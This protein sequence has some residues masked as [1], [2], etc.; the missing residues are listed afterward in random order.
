VWNDI[1]K[2]LICLLDD[3][4]LERIISEQKMW[5]PACIPKTARSK[6][7]SYY[8]PVTLFNYDCKFLGRKITNRL[9]PSLH[10]I[11]HPGK[12]CGVLVRNMH[13]AVAGILD[14][15]FA[16]AELARKSLCLPSLDFSS[17]LYRI[18]HGC[19]FSI[20]QIYGYSS[21]VISLIQCLY[22]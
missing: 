17:W 14:V 15:V 5:L 21:Q 8:P 9:R 6:T 2:D 19:F 11:I 1:K 10:D 22:D 16:D 18:F 12:R 3:M 20:L 13:D 4:R 7:Q